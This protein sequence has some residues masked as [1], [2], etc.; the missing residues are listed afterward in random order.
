MRTYS[1]HGLA[2]ASDLDLDAPLLLK[3]LPPDWTIVTGGSRTVGQD[4]P[5]GDLLAEL[6]F[7][8]GVGYAFVQIGS[9]LLFRFYGTC[10]FEV[11][12]TARRAVAWIDPSSNPG[13]ASLLASGTL[14]SSLLTFN[15]ECVLHASAVMHKNR[16]LAFIGRSGTGKTTLATLCCRAGAALLTDDTLRVVWKGDAPWCFSGTHELRLRPGASSLAQSAEFGQDAVS[17]TID[18]RTGIKLDLVPM[19]SALTALVIPHPSKTEKTLHLQRLQAPEAL[20]KLHSFLR[21]GGWKNRRIIK[22]QFKFLSQLASTLP[23]YR[24]TVPWGPPFADSLPKD[25]LDCCIT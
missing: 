3:S 14:I 19:D 13:I 25:I 4:T 11:D 2:L 9:V 18:K 17:P 12:L 15:G 10:D 8:S 21:V 5:P 6:R 22:E 1:L 24:A 16:G 23:V 20:L 7:K